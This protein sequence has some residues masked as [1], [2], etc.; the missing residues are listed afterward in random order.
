MTARPRRRDSLWIALGL[1]ALAAVLAV[2]QV[3][4][5]L[6][7]V[8]YDQALSWWS[9]PAPPQITIIAIDDASLSAIGRWP[10]PRAV[11]ATLLEQLGAAGPKA[12]ALDL[13]QIGRA[14]V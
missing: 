4:W 8:V 9:R 3:T 1:A 13:V 5:R 10:W 6:D 14:H 12:V 2:T 11:H 7:R